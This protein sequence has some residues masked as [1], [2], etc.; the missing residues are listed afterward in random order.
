M[1]P[2]PRALG[3]RG[4]QVLDYVN[5]AAAS[6]KR[7]PSY[8][9][10]AAALGM[11]STADVCHVIRRLERRGLLMRCDSGSRHSRGWHQPVIVARASK[12]GI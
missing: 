1:K 6:G 3:Y 7:P 9:M 11:S 4:R 2:A 5:S 8:A 10:I 12:E